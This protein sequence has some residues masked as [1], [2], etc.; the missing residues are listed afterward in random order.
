[1]PVMYEFDIKATTKPAIKVVA[2]VVSLTNHRTKGR[3][4]K[5]EASVLVRGV[6]AF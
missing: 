1:M 4:T 2:K 6:I 5:V 3:I